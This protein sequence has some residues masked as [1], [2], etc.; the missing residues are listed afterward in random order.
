M[1][2]DGLLLVE[3]TEH[4]VARLAGRSKDSRAE[5]IEVRGMVREEAVTFLKT[6]GLWNDERAQTLSI[7]AEQVRQDKM[8]TDCRMPKLL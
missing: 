4:E 6:A 5:E 8:S 1:H 3:T 7:V 2:A